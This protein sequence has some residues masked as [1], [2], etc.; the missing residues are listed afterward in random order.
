MSVCR[1]PS[2]SQFF[3]KLALPLL[4]IILILA[5]LYAGSEILVPIAF[6]TLIALLLVG[7]ARSLERHGFPRGAA[8]MVCLL[9][10]LVVF[11]VVFYFISHAIISFR[12][13]L[14]LMM[15]NIESSLKELEVFVQKTLR[16][17]RR[18]AAEMVQ[19]STDKVIPST[20][21]IVNSTV[22]TVTGMVFVGIMV[23]IITFLLL[24]YR[25]LILLF[26]VSL[27]SPTYTGQIT[28]VFAR[29]Q[30][31]IRS[32]IT[33]LL[34]EMVIIAVANTSVLFI[35]GVRY[36]LLL[37]VIGAVLNIIPYVGIFIACVLT[38]LITLTTGT[39]STVLWAVGSLIIIH[40]IDSNILMPRI[41]GS[42][43]N[44][45]AL[46]TIIGV[47][48]GSALWGIPGTFMAVPILAILKVVCEEF[49]PLHAFAIIMGGGDDE[50]R[51]LSGRV[52]RR[53]AG[54]VRKKPR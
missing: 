4:S 1:H 6:S 50:V 45:N 49:E 11:I 38:G 39:P 32:Y 16:I 36:A 52:L 51:P 30:V 17:S 42:K 44:I 24:L 2:T 40:M 48:I 47:I 54:S 21:S 43:V 26:S 53:L 10:A 20:S 19:N 22:N 29:T 23:F 41:M 27:F 8:A 12:S 33:G 46:A 3:S 14:P 25:R 31:M 7:P 34:I 18:D 9:L 37:G 5:L 15:K 28:N 35:L 13:D